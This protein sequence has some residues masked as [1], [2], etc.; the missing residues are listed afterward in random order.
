[1][2]EGEQ[3]PQLGDFHQAPVQI[4]RWESPP[5][6]QLPYQHSGDLGPGEE[7]AGGGWVQASYLIPRGESLGGLW[8][9]P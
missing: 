4:L 2:A 8:F 9:V 1:M 3:W 7:Q 5:H 6:V